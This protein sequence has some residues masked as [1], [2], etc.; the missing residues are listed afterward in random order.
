MKQFLTKQRS[1]LRS[2]LWGAFVATL[3]LATISAVTPFAV[4][5]PRVPGYIWVR[6]DA[7]YAVQNL[8]D[9][10]FKS[11]FFAP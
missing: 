11:A 9:L 3:C 7:P 10:S 8:E 6:Q 4:T 2:T 1:I 5:H